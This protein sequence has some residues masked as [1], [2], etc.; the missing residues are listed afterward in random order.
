M[1]IKE[2]NSHFWAKDGTMYGVGVDIGATYTRVVLAD[3]KGNFIDRISEA[4]IKTGDGLS[5]TYQIIRMIEQ[6]LERND[7]KCQ[8]LM[9]IGIGSIGPLD[10]K[11][12][13][14]INPPN[15]PF[16][17]VPLSEP[18]N[19]AFNVE[20]KVFNDCTAAV[21][22]ERIFGAGKGLD[23]V[24]YITISTGIGGGA[25]VDGHLL[26][27]KDGNAVEIG[28]MVVDPQ[29]LRKCGCGKRG[30]WEAYCSGANIP[31]YAR[32]LLNERDNLEKSLIYEYVRGN[33]EDLT[34]KMIYD[35]AKRD[36]RLALEIIEKVN[37]F[38]AIGVANVINIYDPELIT[39]GGSVVLNNIDLVVKP[40]KDMIKEYA[41]NRIP[42]I[43]VTPLA[44]DV[45]LYGAVA[46]SLGL[47]P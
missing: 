5:L 24:V 35:A 32:I 22:G 27:G 38:N 30:H 42:E 44:G 17:E 4:T 1:D 9:G 39:L 41:M 28:H 13:V 46:L 45:V 8:D 18:L 36:D 10:I 43:K 33:L 11:R 2:T 37:I 14:I 25:Y 3:E 19:K 40:I 20:V 29:G 16:K 26:I 21:V 15:L 34:A 31:K 6:I 7:I 47:A 23:N 12:G